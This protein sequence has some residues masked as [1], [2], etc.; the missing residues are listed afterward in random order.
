MSR[1]LQTETVS[2]A[3]QIGQVEQD[4]LA[5]RQQLLKSVLTLGRKTSAFEVEIE[6]LPSLEAGD[7][8]ILAEGSKKI[9]V[10]RRELR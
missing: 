4:S 9:G 5:L 3:E 7:R 1:R 10:K 2:I 6:W 8:Q